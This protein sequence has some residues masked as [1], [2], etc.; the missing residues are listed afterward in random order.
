MTKQRL[1]GFNQSMIY[2]ASIA[3]MKG[4]SLLILPFITHQLS[5]EEFGQLEVISTLAIIGS[6]LVGMGLE[7]TLFR[8]AGTAPTIE[9]RR[10]IAADIFSLTLIIG[11]IAI[12]AGWFAA[13]TLATWL[14]GEPSVYELRLV[15]SVLALE[16]C[17]A[18]PLGWLRMNNRTVSFFL[19]TCGRAL[20]QAILVIVLLYL[21]RGVAGVLEAGLIAAVAQTLILSYLH[22]H[23]TGLN[24]SLKTGKRSFIYSLPIVGSGLV[25]FALNGLDRWILAENTTLTDVAEFGVATKFALATVLLLQPFG[26]WWSPRRFKVLHE[27]NGREKVAYF[28]A[29]GGSLAL[30]IAVMVG[31]TAPLLITWLLPASYSLAGQYAV[32]LVLVMLVKELVELFNMGCF[33]GNTTGTQLIINILGAAAGVIGMLLL[34]PYFQVWGVI[35]SLLLAQCVRLLF[36]YKASQYFLSLRYPLGSLFILTSLCVFWLLMGSQSVTIG[37]SILITLLATATMLTAVHQLKLITLPVHVL[38]KVAER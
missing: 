16:G 34:T 21:D 4:V 30:L 20:I 25:A 23:D 12:I 36:F 27:I 24:F 3:L 15:L 22:I 8:F 29:V 35:L 9:Q 28:I 32:G 13:K 38:K 14:P 7:D 26:M 2:G 5:T 10:H 37:Q 17:I 1:S 31:L 6:I 33:T 19:V 18:I 11:I